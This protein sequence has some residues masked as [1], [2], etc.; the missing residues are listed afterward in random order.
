LVNKFMSSMV[1]IRL[2]AYEETFIFV[3][4]YKL[5]LGLTQSHNQ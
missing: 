2:P 4:T 5:A 1:W 3:T